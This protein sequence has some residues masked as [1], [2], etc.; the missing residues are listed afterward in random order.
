MKGFSESKL[1]KNT[2]NTQEPRTNSDYFAHPMASVEPKDV[3]DRTLAAFESYLS[4]VSSMY[5]SNRNDPGNKSL[6]EVSS[7]LCN[8]Q[9]GLL[10]GSDQQQVAEVSSSTEEGYNPALNEFH[11]SSL[12]FL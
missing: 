11:Y 12:D 5:F 9:N 7:R 10:M 3:S 8:N 1:I 6:N 4:Q 2:A